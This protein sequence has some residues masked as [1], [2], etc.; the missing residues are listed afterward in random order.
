MAKLDIY[1][2]GLQ[3]IA[4]GARLTARWPAGHSALC[5]QLRRASS[6]IVLNFSEGRGRRTSKDRERFFAIARGSACET[7]ACLDVA[8]A[9]GLIDDADRRR[10]VSSCIAIERGL[11]RWGAG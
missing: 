1:G 4:D 11:R 2:T 5:D 6:S 3:L 10:L 9:L 8:H 7:H